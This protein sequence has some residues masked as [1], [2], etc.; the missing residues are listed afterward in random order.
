MTK[1]QI[2]NYYYQWKNTPMGHDLWCV[3]K[4]P[5]EAKLYAYKKLVDKCYYANGRKPV[6]LTYNT[7]VFTMGYAI[8][9]TFYIETHTKTVTAKISELED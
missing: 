6:V 8:G 3:Y 9:D 4:R 1:K 5:S 7:D 2:K